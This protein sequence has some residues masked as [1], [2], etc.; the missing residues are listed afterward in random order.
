MCVCVLL[1]ACST[2]VRTCTCMCVCLCACVYTCMYKFMCTIY[3]VWTLITMIKLR[4]TYL[5]YII[6]YVI[7]TVYGKTFKGG[8]FRGCAQNTPFTGKLSRCIRPMPLCTV[9]S[10]WFKGK[11]FAIG[12]KTV[13]TAKVSP[14]ESFAV[15]GMLMVTQMVIHCNFK[16]IVVI[17]QSVELVNWVG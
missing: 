13:K 1:R 7:N 10:K 3:V 15:Y 17:V 16:M 9:H 5:V 4:S 11:T 8:N 2:C 12:W 14:L 6:L